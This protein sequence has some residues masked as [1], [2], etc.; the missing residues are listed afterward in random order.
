M[1]KID[2]RIYVPITVQGCVI[3]VWAGT[4][5]VSVPTVSVTKAGAATSLAGR[6]AV[7]VS[8]LRVLGAKPAVFVPTCLTALGGIV[9]TSWPD[10]SPL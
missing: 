8:T 6:S 7:S 3:K 5:V 1:R 4:S 9:A 2:D 10:A